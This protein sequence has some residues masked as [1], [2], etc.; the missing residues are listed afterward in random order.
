MTKEDVAAALMRVGPLLELKGEPSFRT[1]AYQQ[2]RPGHPQF[3]GDLTALVAAGR[4]SA[5]SA[6]SASTLQE[7]ITTLVTTGRLP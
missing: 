5:R 4:V 7:K 3:P 6:A 1:N 2:R